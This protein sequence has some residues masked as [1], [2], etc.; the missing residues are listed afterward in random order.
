MRKVIAAV[1]LLSAC[2]LVF[3]ENSEP[4]PAVAF[5]A[6]APVIDGALD[7]CVRSLP[8]RPLS[9]AVRSDGT[10]VPGPRVTYRIAY[11]ADFL[12]LAIQAPAPTVPSRDRAYQN[13][14]GFHMTLCVPDR[15]GAPTREF[16]VMGFSPW[17]DAAHARQRAFVWYR[18]VDL[19]FTPLDGARLASATSGGTATIELLLPWSLVYPYH[20]WLSKAIAF[21]LC[22]VQAVGEKDRIYHFA[23]LDERMQSEQSPRRYFVLHF[24]RPS[25]PSGLQAYAVLDRNHT[26]AGGM[27]YL[28]LATCSAGETPSR[29][30]TVVSSG[31]GST[32]AAAYDDVPGRKGLA[33]RKLV[34]PVKDLPPGGYR[35]KWSL[36]SARASG[37]TGLTVLPPEGLEGLEKSLKGVAGMISKG[38]AATLAFRLQE[39]RQ[40]MD[41][42]KGYDTAAGLR[43]SLAQTGAIMDAAARG[44]DV[45]ARRA[46]VIRR[47]YLSE[48][49]GTLQPYSMWV[50]KTLDPSKK[51]PLMVFLHGSGED[52]RSV[53]RG[54]PGRVPEGFIGL[55]PSG[56]GTSNCYSADHA[57][58]DIRESMQDVLANYPA[59][60]DRV[61]LA[62]FS[63]G[64]Y[65]VYRTYAENPGAY[66]AIAVFSG[67]PGL[68]T[69]YLGPGQMD[70]LASGALKAF[71]GVHVFIFHGGKDRNCPVEKTRLLVRKLREAGARVEY[72]EEPDKGHDAP[73][74]ETLAAFADWVRRMTR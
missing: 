9:I 1:V 73:G 7:D 2:M 34:V 32:V 4:A 65:G 56:R 12:Y 21:N 59:D 3:A 71:K 6:R 23:V 63:M 41:T 18:N 39:A 5:L 26:S 47:A 49:D 36:P 50:P 24:A 8:V 68:A 44:E 25:A 46:G 53:F 38:S 57:Q 67:D 20:P 22:Y 66:R 14:D 40:T 19:A 70:F 43:L 60:A 58:D 61:I 28:R 11:G 37:E 64:G 27:V 54:G 29:V 45:I 13:G 48:V 51:V 31:E 52:D 55:A 42:I 74:P 15:N 72:H 62:G 69:R 16:Y 17:A 30:R 35:V 10:S 33:V